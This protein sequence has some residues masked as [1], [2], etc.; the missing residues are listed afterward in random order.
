MASGKGMSFYWGGFTHPAGE[1][2][3]AKVERKPL[4]SDR[5]V[6]WATEYLLHVRGDF[7]ST[8]P[9]TDLTPAQVTARVAQ[10]DLAYNDDYKDC[11]F[12]MNGVATPHR[13]LNDDLDNLSGN[14]I[15]Y[16]SWDHVDPAEYCN[17][18]SF[19]IIVRAIFLHARD[20][21]ISFNETVQK[22]GT[23]GKLWTVYDTAN[24]PEKVDLLPRT[25]VT[26]VQ[27]GTVIGT[28]G[29]ILPPP[30]LWPNEEQGW[31]RVVVYTNPRFY[32][33]PRRRRPVH[34]R[35]DY[36]YHFVRFGPDP[37]QGPN[38]YFGP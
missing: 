28:I 18:R 15:A 4:Y 9:G 3:P 25:K 26:H 36:A 20:S 13:M 23:G 12:L 35:T 24:G 19:T 2:Y 5:G 6:R 32:G 31:R 38:W 29:R 34:F 16:R 17:T 1:V 21:V 27:R 8:T 30:P 22:V 33:D 37:I 11:G 7:V 10:M 14:Q